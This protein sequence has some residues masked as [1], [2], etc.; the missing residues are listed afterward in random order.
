VAFYMSAYIM[1][2]VLFMNPFP[3]MNWSWNITCLVPIHEYHST[4]WEENAKNAFYEIFHFIIIPMHKMFHGCESPRISESVSGNIKAIA[5][6]FVDENFS[7]IRVYGC[8]IPPH[9]LPKFLLDRLV[10]REVAHQI[11]KVGIGIEL[12][13]AQKKSWPTFPV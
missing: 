5:D 13:V 3:L 7:Y 9:A 6:W 8:S 12:K 1:D 4:L 10:L 2:V 11:V